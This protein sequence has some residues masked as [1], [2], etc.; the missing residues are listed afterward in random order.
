LGSASALSLPQSAVLLRDGFSYVFRVGP[1]GRVSQVKV[2]VGRRQGDRIEV[3]SGLGLQDAV[4]ASGV[5][6][7][8]DGDVVKIVGTTP[9]PS[10][11]SSPVTRAPLSGP[12]LALATL[13]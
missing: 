1:E 5:G 6:F 13:R 9:A 3:S 4:V 7:L 10:P 2:A 11:A 8:S 12:A